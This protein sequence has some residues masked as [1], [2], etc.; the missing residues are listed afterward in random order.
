MCLQVAFTDEIYQGFVRS[1][2]LDKKQI[3]KSA[4]V[5]VDADT[6]EI[7]LMA[8]MTKSESSEDVLAY[9]VASTGDMEVL[10]TD[11]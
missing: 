7:K 10:S 11:E 4:F 9:F 5:Y 2:Q 1:F 8:N 6:S 3:F